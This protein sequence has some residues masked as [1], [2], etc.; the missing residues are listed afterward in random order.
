[1]MAIERWLK[2]MH[3]YFTGNKLVKVVLLLIL[4]SWYGQCIP[5]GDP[6]G[7]V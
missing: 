6:E 2:K 7:I 4:M 5:K 3:T 1:M